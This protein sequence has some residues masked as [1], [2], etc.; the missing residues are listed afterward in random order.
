MGPSPP[1]VLTRRRVRILF[2]VWADADNVNAQSLNAREIALRLDPDRFEASLFARRPDPRLVG[3][4]N[5][6]VVR[7]PP[8]LRSL[9]MA[10]HLILGAY[11][12]LFYPPLDHLMTWYRAFA[13]TSRHKRIV[14]PIEGTAEQ[15]TA[16]FAP[17]EE[18]RL[19]FEADVAYAC[20]PHVAESVEAA[21]GVR[22]RGVIPVG[23]DTARFAPADRR[24]HQGPAR[25]LCVASIQ[26]RK[27]IH[28][29]LD[30][31][32]AIGPAS[33]EVDVVGDV[34]GS[35]SYRDEL[36][37]RVAEERLSH[38][39]LRGALPQDEVLRWM[40]DADLFVLPSRLE[41]TPKAALEAAA[42]GLPCVVFDDYRTPSVVE[43][44][45]GFQVRTFEEM[46]DRVRIL[47]G[48]RG[49]RMRMGAA[50][51]DV[52]RRF[53][54][55]LIVPLWEEAFEEVAAAVAGGPRRR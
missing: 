26:P 11:D 30:L 47:A 3:H 9:V 15:L 55:S 19:L 27:Q 50:S 49:L 53:D 45:N 42:T 5:V 52:A 25:V 43:G 41:G 2:N 31:A 6:R 44:F 36:L 12:I 21:F 18:Q 40:R 23:V 32:R 33:V 8:R 34:I 54:W 10:R 13:P 1:G 38:V 51:V 20:S 7:L 14:Y 16:G 48:D 39:H 35:P 29:L 46:V 37:R 24:G 17:D 22:P 28:L 4:D